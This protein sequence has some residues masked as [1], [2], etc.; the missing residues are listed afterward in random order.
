MT[1]SRPV[2]ALTFLL[3]LI[4]AAA[5]SGCGTIAEPQWEVDAENTTI[6]LA[7][8]GA[9]ETQIALGAEP[10]ATPTDTPTFTVRVIPTQTPLP[11]TATNTSEPATSTPTNTVEPT[12]ATVEAAADTT[13]DLEAA[14]AA[15]DPVAGQA[16]FALARTMPDGAIWAC[17]QCH[18]V[19]PDELRLIGPGLWNIAVRAETRV[20]GQSALEYIHTSIVAPNDYIVPPDANGAPYPPG[21]MPQHYAN[22]EVLTEADLNN[23]IA[24]LLTLQ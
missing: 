19:T 3:A 8:T 7:A 16:A 9:V 20:E 12:E 1:G 10:T 2:R 5:V 18:S 4:T 11:P 24:Y 22:P 23:I 21:L 6:A 13:S 15:A 17:A 14:V